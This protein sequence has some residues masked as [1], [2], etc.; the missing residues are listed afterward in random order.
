MEIHRSGEDY[1]ETILM[2]QKRCGK[3]R[4]VDICSELGYSKP[5]VS[6][7]VKNLKAD[8]YVEV[9]ESHRIILTEK[10]LAIAENIY[11]RHV[12]IAKF[13]IAIGVDEETAFQDSCKIEHDLS[14]KTFLC[15]KEHFLSL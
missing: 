15:M 10:G 11:E 5:T 9:D 12:V 2:I 4:S 7:A 14:E 1:L 13:L 8:G 3:V 6:V